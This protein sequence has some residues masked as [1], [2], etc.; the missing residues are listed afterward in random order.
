MAQRVVY[1]TLPDT[2]DVA[3]LDRVLEIVAVV[4]RERMD[5]KTFRAW[6]RERDLWDKE[7]TPTA[8]DVVDVGGLVDRSGPSLGPIAEALGAA[9]DV[10]AARKV[11]YESLLG[12]NILLAKH[13]LEALDVEADG[14]L[15]STHEL[16]RYVTSYAYP[17]EYIRLPAFQ[18]Y[19]TWLQAAGAI[20][21][22][23]IRWDSG[24]PV[25]RAW[26]GCVASM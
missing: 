20:R 17:G 12:Q 15:H 6:M 1:A 9:A 18:A 21:T 26:L 22:I 2:P 10:D 5:F 13:V 8:L 23:G 16:Y 14:R 19:I 4:S 11:L 3:L 24:R 25:R 7:R